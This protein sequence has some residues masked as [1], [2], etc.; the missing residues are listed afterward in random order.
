MPKSERK[1]FREK[2]RRDRVNSSFEELRALII[3]IDPECGHRVDISQLEL[4]YRSIVV[5]K[6]LL[7]EIETNQEILQQIHACQQVQ[8]QQ[9]QQADTNKTTLANTVGSYTVPFVNPFE[10]EPNQ[11]SLS[12]SQQLSDFGSSQNQYA[13]A[14]H[15]N[16][17]D[18]AAVRHHLLTMTGD[19]LSHV[20]ET[21][22]SLVRD[23]SA[24]AAECE[25]HNTGTNPMDMWSA[26][27][28][29]IGTAPAAPAMIQCSHDNTGAYA[30][31]ELAKNTETGTTG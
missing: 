17:D 23:S 26:L 6:G 22:S 2:R 24:T 5:I 21:G 9:Q 15:P 20:V 8:Q 27:D 4:V 11:P 19:A 7:Q 25:Q 14:M 13:P 18:S 12:I 29:P 30:Q 28:S 3:R 31:L 1:R 10:N 16:Q